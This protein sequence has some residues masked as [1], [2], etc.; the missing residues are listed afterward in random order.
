[1]WGGALSGFGYG[2]MRI[3]N[4]NK[5]TH[6]IAWEIAYGKIPEGVYVLHT[7]NIPPCVLPDHLYLGT[8]TD[9]MQ[10]R[11]AAGNNP[12]Y[13]KTHCPRGHVYSKENIYSYAGRRHCRICKSM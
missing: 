9:N 7:C 13:N 12:N 8:A 1:M 2:N 4:K 10:D 5:D 11:L 6:R 3:N